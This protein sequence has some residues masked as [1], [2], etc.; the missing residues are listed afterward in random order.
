M[1]TVSPAFMAALST[2]HQVVTR[3]DAYL[4][5]VLTV[6]DL[7][8]TG[9]SV[10]VDR[11]SKVRRSLS[12]TLADPAYLPWDVSDPLAVYG[13]QLAVS[14][15]IQFPD[16]SVELAPLGLF[17]V[18][19]PSGDVDMGPV[20][21]SGKSS[22]AII[23]DARFLAPWS[24]ADASSTVGA[25]TDLI[26]DV[27]PTATVVNLTAGGRD[28]ACA[29]VVWD[30]Q[31]DRWDAVTQLATSM[32]AEVYV[33]VSDRFVLV[34]VPDLSAALPVWDVA[35]GP[36][37]T[38]IAAGRTMSRAGVYNAVIASGES[39]ASGIPPVSGSAYDTDPASPTRWG[40][41]Y[42]KVPRFYSS[43]LLTTSADCDAVAATLLRDALAPN[44][45]TSISSL[46]N[47]ALEA[48]DCLR[49]TY[50]GGRRDLVLAQAFSVPLDVDGDFAITLRGSKEDTS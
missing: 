23:Q 12:L 45:Q 3:V 25:I 39:T 37:G 21:V 31:A 49:L 6:A 1:Y 47:P 40:G 8:H 29:T 5:G 34:D 32:R 19:E 9:G 33:D 46:P 15:G 14:R 11:G 17:R 30:A 22:E 35:E 41:P 26:H 18:D 24:T 4:G 2:S 38:L 20:T 50:A 44:V 7:P 16:G 42:G 27:I 48:G 36:T 10:T 43:G 28:Q 13:Q